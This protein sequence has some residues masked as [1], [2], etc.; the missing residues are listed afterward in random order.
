M[1]ACFLEGLGNVAA[2]ID[3][4]P[5]PLQVLQIDAPKKMWRGGVIGQITKERHD[6]GR[7]FK[8]ARKQC[9]GS[10]SCKGVEVL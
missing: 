10:V 1:G 3:K 7:I 9:H 6:K 8:S 2:P 4:A 5:N